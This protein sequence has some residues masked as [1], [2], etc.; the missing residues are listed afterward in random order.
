MDT[1][2]GALLTGEAMRSNQG[3]TKYNYLCRMFPSSSLESDCRWRACTTHALSINLWLEGRAK[4]TCTE[5][6]Q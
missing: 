4:L 1:H 2:T 3:H 6:L 5:G